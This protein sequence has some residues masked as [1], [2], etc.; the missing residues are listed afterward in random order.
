MR[1]IILAALLALG[2]TVV[3]AADVKVEGAWVR[4]TT[5]SQKATGAFMK[6]TAASRASLVGAASPVAG[7]VEVHEMKLLADNM[8]MSPV[9]K[10][11]LPAG[12]TVELK[13]G[14]YHVMLMDL[15]QQV[16]AGD[17][18]PLTLEIEQ[19]GKREKIEVEAAVRPLG[20]ASGHEHM[21]H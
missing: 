6:L 7:K 11:A 19:D 15:R 14:G 9:Q 10:L 20:D 18:V 4:G 17:I 3:S 12:K 8:K 2:S 16:K 13:P 5:P 1:S 21:Q